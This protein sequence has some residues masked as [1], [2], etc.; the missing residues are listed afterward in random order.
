MAISTTKP[1]T[2]KYCGILFDVPLEKGETGA[3]KIR[4]VNDAKNDIKYF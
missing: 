4:F 2:I 3:P 1:L